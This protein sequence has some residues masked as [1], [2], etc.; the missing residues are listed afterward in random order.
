M[1]RTVDGGNKSNALVHFVAL[2]WLGCL[3]AVV[4]K[5]LVAGILGI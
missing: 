3:T 5:V 2:L 4:T 1:I